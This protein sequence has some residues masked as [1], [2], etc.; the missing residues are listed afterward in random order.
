MQNTECLRLRSRRHCKNH[1]APERTYPENQNSEAVPM[2]AFPVPFWQ[3]I[4]PE[5]IFGKAHA[6][7]ILPI[8]GVFVYTVSNKGFGTVFE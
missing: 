6:A 7:L 5:Y 8:C 4:E 3:E 2:E 1:A